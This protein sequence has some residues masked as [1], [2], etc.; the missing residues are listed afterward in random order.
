MDTQQR[1]EAV[2]RFAGSDTQRDVFLSVP[3]DIGWAESDSNANGCVERF[4]LALLV[5]AHAKV[6]PHSRQF[7]GDKQGCAPKGIW[8]S[9]MLRQL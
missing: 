9:P 2:C 6:G 5:Q 4:H 8:H 3:F 1:A 7:L